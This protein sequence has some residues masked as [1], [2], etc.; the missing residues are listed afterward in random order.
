[1]AKYHSRGS[2]AASM[3]SLGISAHVNCW[4]AA[5]ASEPCT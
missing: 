5:S 1:M 3:T 2:L 4:L